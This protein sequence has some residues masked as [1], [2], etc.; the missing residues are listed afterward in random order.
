MTMPKY[1]PTITTGDLIKAGSYALVLVVLGVSLMNRVETLE[2]GLVRHEDVPWHGNVGVR[3]TRIE[4]EV[5]GLSK[6]VDRQTLIL[7]D[8]RKEMQKLNR[9]VG[10]NGGR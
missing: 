1:D 3:V 9:E 7:D 4:A 2:S 8:I 10:A 6:A 5:G